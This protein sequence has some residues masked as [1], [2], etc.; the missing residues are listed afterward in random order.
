V[1]Q[2]SLIGVFL[3]FA[4]VMTLPASRA[5][6]KDKDSK[7]P[8]VEA[9]GQ[10]EDKKA[11]P[12]DE[13]KKDEEKKKSPAEIADDKAVEAQKRGDSAWMLVSTA[14]VMLMV[15]GLALF[16]GGMVRR[17]NVLATMMQSM[18]CLSVVGVF[19]IAIGY[20]LAFGDPWIMIGGKGVLG[21][22]PEL[23]FLRGIKPDTYVPALNIPVY[24]H[25]AYQ[26]MFAIITPALISGALAE[27]IKFK[28]YLAFILLW[29]VF[30]YCPL[31]QSVW[32]MN[33]NWTYTMLEDD[34]AKMP[35]AKTAAEKREDYVNAKINGIKDAT[36]KE[37]TKKYWEETG[38]KMSGYLGAMGALDFAG[39]TVVH[40]AAG[41]SSLACFL[42]LRKRYGYPEKAFHPNSM[43]LTLTGAGLLWFGWFGFNGGSALSSSS[44]AVSAFTATQAAAAAAGL[45][46]SLVEWFHRGKPTALGF[47]SGVVAG[48]VAVTPAS[49]FVLPWAGL[50]I[51]ALAGVVCYIAV[52]AKSIFKYDDSL[53]AFGVHGIGGFLGAVLTGVFCLKSVN[54]VGAD[55]MFYVTGDDKFKQVGIQLYAALFSVILAFVASLVI[56]KL[57]DLVLG[58]TVTEDEEITGLDR[59]EHGE[60][61]FDLGLALESV[62]IPLVLEPKAAVRPP[63]GVKQY[64]VVVDGA[65][66]D[67]LSKAWSDMCTPGSS[68]SADFKAVYS[69]LTT[70]QGNRFK[71]RG[72]DSNAI[73][74]GLKRLLEARL[75]KAVSAKVE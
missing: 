43:V 58:F 66:A 54:S 30:V 65:S 53:D 24:L 55:G 51:G 75:K 31:A 32:A 34:D 23:V 61:G 69:N 45:S 33:W 59:V 10:G 11:D 47:A 37:D 19:W 2:W 3:A 41:L 67:D 46:W 18:I 28:S 68:T 52:Y 38:T 1:K 63:N 56:C 16:Y 26:G 22:S 49:G 29:M 40:I 39:G 36:E 15:P 5:Q 72:G 50:L 74:E 14:F 44:L 21:W 17:K 7:D 62:S 71:F 27:R 20:S 57:V 64:S 6:E 73:K 13:A 48:L 35:K 70:F 12:K 25:M 4:F 42:V 60:T 9:K 8:V